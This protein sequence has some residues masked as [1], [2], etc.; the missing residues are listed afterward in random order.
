MA[1]KKSSSRKSKSRVRS[2]VKKGSSKSKKT[3][4]FATRKHRTIAA[5]IMLVAV[6]LGFTLIAIHEK[7]D[8]PTGYTVVKETR[9]QPVQNVEITNYDEPQGL[10]IP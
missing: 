9:E 5:A 10:V 1:K 8:T 3:G 2:K 7:N 4:R 6:L